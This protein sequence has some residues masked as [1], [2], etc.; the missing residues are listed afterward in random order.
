MRNFFIGLLVLLVVGFLAAG[1]A[2]VEAKGP[3]V[4]PNATTVTDVCLVYKVDGVFSGGI[5]VTWPA[6]VSYRQNGNDGIFLWLPG[7]DRMRV[8]WLGVGPLPPDRTCVGI[9]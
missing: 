7:Q 1:S 9:V 8:E 5:P 2:S 3:P 4:T 6:T